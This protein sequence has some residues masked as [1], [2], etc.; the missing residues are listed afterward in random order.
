MK[1]IRSRTVKNAVGARGVASIVRSDDDRGY[2]GSKG[3]S[4]VAERLISLMPLHNTYVAGFAGH[5]AVFFRKRP[6]RSSIVIDADAD[7]A[8]W[9]RSQQLGTS[10]LTIVPGDFFEWV[11]SPQGKAIVYD[12]LTFLYIDPPYMGSKRSR[13]KR[14]RCELNTPEGHT[15]LLRVLQPLHCMVMISGY[16]SDLY[17]EELKGWR[18]VRF[19]AGVR[20]G[21]RWEHVWM[22]FAQGKLLHDCRYVGEGYRERD[23][24]KRKCGRWVRRLLALS[25]AERQFILNS[26]NAADPNVISDGEDLRVVS[27]G[28]RRN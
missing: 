10:K 26:L 7:V 4:G 18:C 3:G 28:A 23:R 9:W 16:Y 17:A 27:I 14:Y 6:A 22:N 12:P 2:F 13:S 21:S 8:R 25:D 24:I 19:R 20:R 15:R 1:T 5:D 11:R